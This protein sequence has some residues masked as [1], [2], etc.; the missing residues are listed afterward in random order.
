M[1][2]AAEWI[3]HLRVSSR[4]EMCVSYS[5]KPLNRVKRLPVDNR[6]MGITNQILRKLVPVLTSLFLD[7]IAGRSLAKRIE[8]LCGTISTRSKKFKLLRMRNE[9][10]PILKAITVKEENVTWRR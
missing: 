5:D 1:D 3:T 6:L 10:Q 9:K 7:G 8:H 2:A 4:V